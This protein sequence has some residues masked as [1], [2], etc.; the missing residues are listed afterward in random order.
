[1]GVEIIKIEDSLVSVLIPWRKEYIIDPIKQTI[2]SGVILSL[3]DTAGW[4]ATCSALKEIMQ[5][6]TLDM[7]VDYLGATI[8]GKSILVEAKCYYK[9]NE[10]A[11]VQATVSQKN[12]EMFAQAQSTFSLKPINLKN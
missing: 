11:F 7:R 12:N 9:K 1:M 5:I 4:L 10:I 8:K 6:A 3:V 2:N